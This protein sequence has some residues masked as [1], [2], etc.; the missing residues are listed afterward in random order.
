MT[1]IALGIVALILLVVGIWTVFAFVL[2]ICL[3][4]LQKDQNNNLDWIQK[5]QNN[6]PDWLENEL[7]D[8]GED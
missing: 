5:D 1:Q 8:N 7:R 3:D 2:E 6:K 4:W